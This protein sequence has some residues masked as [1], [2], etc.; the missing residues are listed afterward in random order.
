MRRQQIYSSL[1]GH[2]PVSSFLSRAPSL[3]DAALVVGAMVGAL[4]GAM[5]GAALVG[6]WV[7]TRVLGC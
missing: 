7:G 5:V 4:V 1:A 2:V 6:A 3:V